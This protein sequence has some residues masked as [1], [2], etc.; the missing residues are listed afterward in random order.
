MLVLLA[1]YNYKVIG[2]WCDQGEE[3]HKAVF[4]AVFQGDQLHA[5]V[6]KICEG[7]AVCSFKMWSLCLRA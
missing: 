4:L 6:R 3:T 5:K 1:S 2:D 7:L